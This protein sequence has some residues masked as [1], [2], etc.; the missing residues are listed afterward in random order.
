MTC[1]WDALLRG[2]KHSDVDN[3]LGSGASRS[4]RAFVQALKAAN[5]YT[6]GVRWQ[7]VVVR[8]TQLRENMTW[9]R[10][11]DENAIGGGHLTSSADPF[12]MLISYLFHVRIR[13]V[14]PGGTIEYMPATRV[15]YT[16]GLK[17]RTGHMAFA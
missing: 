7:G 11:Y 17:S 14:R 6:S 16:V 1:V 15:R 10:E 13:H 2:L 4:P 8:A 5:L 12:F 3:L 9:I